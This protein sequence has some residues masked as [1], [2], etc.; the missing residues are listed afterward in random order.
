M[1]YI[2]VQEEKVSSSKDIFIWMRL[3]RAVSHYLKVT[4]CIPD[5]W[6]HLKFKEIPKESLWKGVF[7]AK[8]VGAI[9]AP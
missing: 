5:I 4:S 3:H 7:V 1:Q 6:K 9:A 2:S 8:M